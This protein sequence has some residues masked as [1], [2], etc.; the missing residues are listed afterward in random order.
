MEILL[1]LLI[2][3]AAGVSSGLFGIGGGIIIV[4]L[5]LL[6]FQMNQQK[7]Q[8]TSLL[9]LLAP[10]GLL[11]VKNYWEDQQIDVLKG[12]WVA[13]GLFGG[14]YAGSKLAL[15]LDPLLMRRVF[16]GFLVCVAAYLFVKP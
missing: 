2:G 7:A 3:L 5:L 14:A 9:I 4:P 11:A 13:V 10:V 15:G 1:C 6:A 8:G 16:A 12:V